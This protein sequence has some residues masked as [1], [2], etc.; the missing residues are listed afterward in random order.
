MYPEPTRVRWLPFR[1]LPNKSTGDQVASPN[2]T[3]ER[4]IPIKHTIEQV[5]GIAESCGRSAAPGVFALEA[6][7]GAFLQEVNLGCKAKP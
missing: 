2:I 1:K 3:C 4:G 6:K 7:S 5:K